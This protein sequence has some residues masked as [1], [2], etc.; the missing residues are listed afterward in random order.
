MKIYKKVEIIIIMGCWL[1]HFQTKDI[2]KQAEVKLKIGKNLG[3]KEKSFM[4]V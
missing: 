2:F 4:V 3:L 1:I